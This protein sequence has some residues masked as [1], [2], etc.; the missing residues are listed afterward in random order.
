MIEKKPLHVILRLLYALTRKMS[1]HHVFSVPLNDIRVTAG[2]DE[3]LEIYKGTDE[4]A[5]RRL[6]S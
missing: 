2:Q 6:R 4:D 3:I 1:V 5:Q